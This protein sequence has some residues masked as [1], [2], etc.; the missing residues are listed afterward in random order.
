MK[1][2]IKPKGFIAL[3]SAILI[4]N[5]LL[6]VA[7]AGSLKGFYTRADILD[8]EIKA[9]SNAAADACADVALLS[10]VQDPNYLGG[11]T[12]SLNKDDVCM[13]RSVTASGTQKIIVIQATSTGKAVTNLR[14]VYATDSRSVVSWLEVPN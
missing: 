2:K 9:R 5:V 12:H 11:D 1:Q 8:S 4:S 3:M 14:V 6:I 7:A 10:L 13:V